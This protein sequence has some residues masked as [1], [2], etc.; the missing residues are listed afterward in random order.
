M[1]RII[2]C[3]GEEVWEGKLQSEV[4]YLCAEG[5]LTVWKDGNIIFQQQL[6]KWRAYS[7]NYTFGKLKLEKMFEPAKKHHIVSWLCGI[8]V[9]AFCK[10]EEEYEE[11]IQSYYDRISPEV[12]SD[13]WDVKGNHYSIHWTK[14]NGAYAQPYS[15]AGYIDKHI[16]NTEV[17]ELLPE[18]IRAGFSKWYIEKI[19]AQHFNVAADEL[20][21]AMERLN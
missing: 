1:A 8:A 19:L 13:E 7:I 18:M 4:K 11:K 10:S 12:I 17:L 15:V 2:L 20:E 14:K 3:P 9:E 6:N 16:T 21:A 5:Y